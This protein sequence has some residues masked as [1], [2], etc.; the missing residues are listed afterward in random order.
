MP[1]WPKDTKA[2][3]ANVNQGSDQ[4]SQA[5]ADIL[6]NI[7]NVN[8][9]IDTFDLQ[10]DSAGQ[11]ANGDVLQYNSTS[12]TWQP[13]PQNAIQSGAAEVGY[14]F[15]RDSTIW[16][17]AADGSGY[18][19]MDLDENYSPSWM[20]VDETNKWFN[21]TAGDYQITV[22]GSFTT[23]ASVAEDPQLGIF[24]HFTN[25]WVTDRSGIAYT[26][27][28][29]AGQTT[30]PVHTRQIQQDSAGTSWRLSL[31]GTTT[32]LAFGDTILSGGATVIQIVKIS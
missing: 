13:V 30:G 14:I 10:P 7:T 16:S 32:N 27:S 26:I 5:R 20:S 17:H 31:S 9:I 8:T 24:N 29:T 21:L 12:G 15:S 19:K 11:P 6:Q 18:G 22:H 2:S 23:T 1:T 28:V 25:D 3:I 4:I